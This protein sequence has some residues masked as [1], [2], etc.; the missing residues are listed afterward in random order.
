MATGSLLCFLVQGMLAAMLAEFIDFHPVGVIAAILLG[1][2]IAVLALIACQ[3]DD[4]SNIFL[5]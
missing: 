2:V 3:R 1:G 4:R 5:F